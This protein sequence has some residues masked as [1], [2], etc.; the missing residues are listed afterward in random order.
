VTC[1]VGR[2][3][4]QGVWVRVLECEVRKGS[5]VHMTLHEVGDEEIL[6]G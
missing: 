3:K 2:V 6:K 1:E 5:E 4:A